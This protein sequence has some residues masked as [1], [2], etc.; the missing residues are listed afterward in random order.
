MD[1]LRASITIIPQ[2]PELLSGTV[3]QNLDPFDEHDDAVLHSALRS[4]GLYGLQE[5]TTESRITL[6]TPVASGGGNLSL[7]QRQILALARAITRRSKLLILDEATAA[8]D[9]ATDAA[10]QT[11]LRTELG[12]VTLITVAHRL[13]TVMDAD[14]IV[15]AREAC[16]RVLSYVR[17]SLCSMM[18]GSVRICLEPRACLTAVQWSLR[19]RVSCWRG[20]TECCEPLWTGASTAMSS[21]PSRVEPL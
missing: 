12:E 10:I 20:R 18:G 5:E 17:C 11:A 2:Q 21:L 13:R 8:V 7:G 15:R 9:H 6:D 4:A 3:R 19:R 1:A 16:P 14:K